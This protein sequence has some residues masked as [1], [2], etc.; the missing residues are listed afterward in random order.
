MPSKK[1]LKGILGCNAN[2]LNSWIEDIDEPKMQI[3][4][5]KGFILG[6]KKELPNSVFEILLKRFGT[7]SQILAG[8]K[9]IERS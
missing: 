6:S 9:L 7:E 1:Q 3:L 2:Q 8:M 4:V 5:E